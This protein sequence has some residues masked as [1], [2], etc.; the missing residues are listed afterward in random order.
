RTINDSTAF[1][2]FM[3]IFFL[4]ISI[5]KKG[6]MV[7]MRILLIGVLICNVCAVPRGLL[8]LFPVIDKEIS[9]MDS[10]NVEVRYKQNKLDKRPKCRTLFRRLFFICTVT[11]HYQHHAKVSF[12]NLDRSM[13]TRSIVR[14][15]LCPCKEGH[16]TPFCPSIITDFLKNYRHEVICADDYDLSLPLY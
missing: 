16:V 12:E 8:S 9:P 10:S 5:I 15:A 3:R 2:Y 7:F 14:N 4:P 11:V 6:T 13:L 1:V